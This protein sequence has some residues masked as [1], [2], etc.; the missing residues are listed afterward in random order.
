MGFSVGNLKII[1]TVFSDHKTV[2]FSSNFTCDVLSNVSVPVSS[3]VLTPYTA[4]SFSAASEVSLLLTLFESPC[5]SMDFEE[6][7]N[8][9]NASCS[10][11]LDFVAPFKAKNGCQIS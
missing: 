4:S 6:F 1:D 10:A 9:F 11:N 7:V 3:R 8:Q 2:L 5:H